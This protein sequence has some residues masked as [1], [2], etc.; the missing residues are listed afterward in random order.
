M[1]TATFV[2]IVLLVIVTGLVGVFY[3]ETTEWRNLAADLTEL[4][5]KILAQNREMLEY[6]KDIDQEERRK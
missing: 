1:E 4:N 3:K 5:D 2:L 6:I